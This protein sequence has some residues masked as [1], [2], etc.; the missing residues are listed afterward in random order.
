MKYKRL[1]PLIVPVLVWLLAEVFLAQP[2]FFYF[3]LTFSVLLLILGIKYIS[4]QSRKIWSL[5]IISPVLFLLSFLTYT[6]IIV[7]YFW[8]QTIYLLV[9]WFTFFYLRNFYYYST[10]LED[11]AVWMAKQDNLL[12]SGGFLTAFATAAVLFDLSAFITW[13]IYVMLP[14]W[15]L[16]VWLLLIQFRPLKPDNSWPVGGLIPI[17]VL[18]LTELA[19]VFSLLPLNY[20]ILALFLAIIYYID[21]M[22]IRLI[23]SGALNRRAL[24]L[25]LILSFMAILFLFLTA[26]WL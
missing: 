26:S 14:L 8:I 17:S 9:V 11:R 4:G 16:V 18:I 21:L 24:K 23:I 22:I 7:N 15:A 25:P 5:F 2:K 3:S 1:I 13:P 19:G 6:A 12:I 20:N 10:N